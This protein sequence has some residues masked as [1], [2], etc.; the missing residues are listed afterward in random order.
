MT[1]GQ[2]IQQARKS[3]GLS[4]KQLGDRLGLSASMIG[5]WENDLRNPKY[6]TLNRIANALGIDLDILFSDREKE[7]SEWSNIEGWNSGIGAREKG[8]IEDFGYQGYSFSE[9]EHDL[10]SAFDDLNREGQR[11]AIERIK[12]LTEIP[13]YRRQDT[14][15]TP[16]E[17]ERDRYGGDRYGGR[18]DE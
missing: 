8:V 3:A 14:P 12:E 2:R 1:T 17:G 13:R 15:E 5:Q 18:R 7:I 10:I 16:S 9:A 6:D 11:K 4:Q